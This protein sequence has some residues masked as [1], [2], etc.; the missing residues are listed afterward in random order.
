VAGPARGG[1]TA[2][3]LQAQGAELK[4]IYDAVLATY[5]NLGAKLE[6]VDLP[7]GLLAAAQPLNFILE[8]EAAATF[9]DLT[10]SGE[11]NLLSSGTS[12]STWPNTFRQGR[13][14]PAVEYIRAMRARTLLMRQADDFF[15]KYDAVL[16]PGT[17]GTLSLTNLTGH[18][19]MA[20]KCGFTT[21]PGYSSGQPRVLMITGRL[22]DEATICRI[23]LAYEQAT[24]WK[25]RHPHLA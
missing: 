1:L 17:G 11:V 8:V 15:S 14:V 5:Q 3:Q 23:A 25:D 13:L 24:E 7:D 4:K 9:D 10:R 21:M 22:Y 2:E 18:P 6:A 19:A 16:E 12:R 20:L